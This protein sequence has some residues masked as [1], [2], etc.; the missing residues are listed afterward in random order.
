MTARARA[1]AWSMYILATGRKPPDIADL[2]RR[3]TETIESIKGDLGRG[4]PG[5][6]GGES[7]FI[8]MISP[9]ITEPG[10][11]QIDLKT[12]AC[13]PRRYHCES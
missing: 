4:G 12:G 7:L 13:V 1:L 9:C 10:K 3:T 6:P 5:G 11:Y 2:V 8:I